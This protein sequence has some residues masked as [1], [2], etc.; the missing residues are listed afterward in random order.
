LSQKEKEKNG[1]KGNRKNS[2]KSGGDVADSLKENSRKPSGMNRL[3]MLL[4]NGG[5]A[6][7]PEKTAIFTEKLAANGETKDG[8]V[9]GSKDGG[10][11]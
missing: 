2:T 10:G 5:R 11:K 7:V 8:R 6:E 9:S 4:K 3:E 1:V